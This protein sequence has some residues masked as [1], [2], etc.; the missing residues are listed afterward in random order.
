M[1]HGEQF[2]GCSQDVFSA[3]A[4]PSEFCTRD[5]WQT[6]VLYLAGE[7]E[8]YGLPS[9]CTRT[10][11][12]E[13]QASLDVIALVNSCWQLVQLYRNSQRTV[14][15]METLARRT[16]SDRD[17]LLANSVKQR[18]AINQRERAV[19]DSSEKERQASEQVETGNLKLKGAKDEVRRLM[20]VLLQRESKY[21]HEMR[22]AE[23]ENAKLKERLLKVLVDKGEG[24]GIGWGIE[25]VGTVSKTGPRAKWNTEQTAKRE[26]LIFTKVIDEISRKEELN[27]AAITVLRESVSTLLDSLQDILRDISVDFQPVYMPL[28]LESDFLVERIRLLCDLLRESLTGCKLH[29]QVT[30]MEQKLS[31]YEEKLL[32]YEKIIQNCE[33]N[34][35]KQD[36]LLIELKTLRKQSIDSFH[37]ERHDIDRAKEAL[38]RERDEIYQAH[39][40]LETAKEE[41]LQSDLCAQA[42]EDLESDTVPGLLLLPRQTAER[43]PAWALGPVTVS[44]S[45]IRPPEE[46]PGAVLGY[47]TSVSRP[48][49]RPSSR[50]GSQASS[51]AQSL[52]RDQAKQ[53]KGKSPAASLICRRNSRPTD[54]MAS[55][56]RKTR[57]KSA[58]ISPVRGSRSDASS[59]TSSYSATYRNKSA[60]VSRSPSS[61]REL[62]FCREKTATNVAAYSRSL[63]R[64]QLSL[65]PGQPK[66]ASGVWSKPPTPGPYSPATSDSEIGFNI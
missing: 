40:D 26:E 42:A 32:I 4:S 8:T 57:P 49:S 66:R 50:P 23:Q 55:V 13:S 61:S 37:Q 58:N 53:V 12:E 48:A 14:T 20:S 11:G 46:G 22:R 29:N 34:R 41:Q 24:K 15:E 3:N 36:T 64:G 10:V 43:P 1:E 16:A 59:M 18:E 28:E 30:V 63:P 62:N 19:A 17:R 33:T 54:G 6:A 65:K 47:S 5:N 51:R 9:P 60:G 39:L 21:S 45:T 2:I 38:A 44:P 35:D 31:L 56:G 25:M 7:L 52:S 27:R